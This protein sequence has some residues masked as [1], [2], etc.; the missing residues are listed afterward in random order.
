M[1]YAC[2]FALCLF[3]CLH[4]RFKLVVLCV[5]VWLFALFCVLDV[6]LLLFVFL[7]CFFVL[8]CFIFRCVLV[9]VCCIQGC[10]FLIVGVP[11][12][13]VVVCCVVVFCVGY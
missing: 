9:S 5:R 1:S 6:Y 10:L 7:F 8:L 4:V 11:L 3:L 13:L 2:K 12:F